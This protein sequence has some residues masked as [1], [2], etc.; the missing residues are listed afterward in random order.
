MQHYSRISTTANS[1]ISRLISSE[2]TTRHARAPLRRRQ[3]Q[4][5]GRQIQRR[6]VV[7]THLLEQDPSGLRLS[8]KCR[9]GALVLLRRRGRRLEA[10]PVRPEDGQVVNDP[11]YELVLTRKVSNGPES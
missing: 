7:L 1:D 6:A 10:C 3:R 4:A 2:D 5:V 8:H 11:K 9:D